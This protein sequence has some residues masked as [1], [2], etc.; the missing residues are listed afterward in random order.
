MKRSLMN[1]P[2]GT[3]DWSRSALV[4]VD[5]QNDFC[6]AE[7][8]AARNG[9]DVSRHQAIVPAIR[10]AIDAAHAAH[11][12][13]I[14]AI[15]HHDETTDAP[16]WKLRHTAGGAPLCRTGSW[17]TAHFGVA[18]IDG[19]IEI[20]KHRYSAFIGT[21]LELRLR[22]MGV[23]NVFVAGVNTGICVESS[24]RD[25]Y[26]LDFYTFALADA[27]SCRTP[28][29]HA[30]ALEAIAHGFGWVIDTPRMAQLLG[31]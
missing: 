4:V 1:E 21:D 8:A 2:F 18:P 9:A 11:I 28:E 5:M 19:D 24:V 30:A 17:G 27:T 29:S 6:H 10:R 31:A 26:M 22:A 16:S 3:L 25:G 12:P 13:V 14:F 15:T 23:E 7:G 20:V